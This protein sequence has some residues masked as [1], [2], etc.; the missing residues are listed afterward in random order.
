VYFAVLQTVSM[1]S[2]WFRV[3][4]T[5]LQILKKLFFF[6]MLMIMCPLA[7]YFISKSLIFEGFPVSLINVTFA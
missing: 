4:E 1:L 2:V 7:T 6:S 3:Q 5:P